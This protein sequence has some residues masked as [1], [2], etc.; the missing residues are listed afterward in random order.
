M[1]NAAELVG[2][3]C[4][5]IFFTVLIYL[6]G[7]IQKT[8]QTIEISQKAVDNI[9]NLGGAGISGAL[10]RSFLR[11]FEEFGYDRIGISCRLEN[12]ICEMG[13]VGPADGG[14]YLVKG[15]GIPRIDIVGFNRNTDWN[16]LLGKLKQIAAGVSP[17]VE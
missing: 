16:V 6:L 3:S 15:G 11:F 17:V 13:G 9:S 7:I 1:G 8:R 12:G 5:V 2:A 10:S 14:Y 4:V